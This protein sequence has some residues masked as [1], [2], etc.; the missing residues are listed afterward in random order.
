MVS[1]SWDEI[2]GM[3]R[4]K[5]RKFKSRHKQAALKSAPVDAVS[6]QEAQAIAG[7]ERYFEFFLIAA[8]LSFGVYQSVLYFGHKLIP[9]PDF[10]CFAQLGH[11]LLSFKLPSS[12]MR[13]P[14]LGLLQAA[15]SHIVGGQRP[16]LTAGWLLNAIFHPFNL[17]L[18]YL[19][20]KRI[21]GKSALWIAIIAILNPWVIYML[22]EPVV[23]TT[24]LFFT[25]LTFYFI[26]K[27]SKWSYVFASIATMVRYE[28]AALIMA[29]FVMDMIHSTS[30]R[31]R[32]HALLYS[33]LA[34]LPLA[35][36]MLGTVLTWK[37]QTGHYF[38]VFT[39][40][41]AEAFTQP[42]EQRTG[43]V[44]HSKLLWE[45]GFRP[46]LLS[47]AAVKAMFMFSRLTAAELSSM[48]TLF[49]A[50]QIITAAS[51]AFGSIYGLCKRRWEILFL[52]LFL[53]PYFL[54]HARYPYP[55]QRFHINIFWIVLL[56]CLFGLQ[57]IWPARRT[58]LWVGGRLLDRNGRAPKGLVVVLQVLIAVISAVWLVSL[59]LY[60]PK[61]ASISPRSVWLPFVAMILAG[62]I[63]AGRLYVHK[64]RNLLRELSILALVCLIIVSNQF[65]LVRVVG[66]G[67]TE[68]EFKDLA[69][70]YIANARA[71]EK[72]GVYMATVV[73]IFAPKFA[74]D[75]VA[76]PKADSPEEFVKACFDQ[77]ITYV[78]WATRE[79]AREDHTGYRQLGLHKNIAHLATPKSTGPYQFVTQV[80]SERGYVNIFSLRR[81]ADAAEPAS[82]SP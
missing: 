37:A 49:G 5:D 54:L 62:L 30:R 17:V 65:S 46:L 71:G 47:T 27:R 9:N 41:Y 57:S 12:F 29:A 79:G 58:S 52:L 60:L 40:Q 2:R 35:L 70:W 8:L 50:S 51:F 81:P 7:R 67:Q 66:D 44:L 26:L 69:D 45:V 77:N 74:Q 20:G 4:Q 3:S 6:Q 31:Q 80:G 21:V 36:W 64:L 63:F 16:D 19:V 34:A 13:A 43:L 72:M 39:K 14:V 18:L 28:G 68:K 59:V 55:F 33:A 73:K 38:D 1:R 23:E 11:E 24:L 76:L 48:R 42:V 78:V 10:V 53:V 32:I 22:T 56:I 25:L 15:L 75:I 82:G 61:I